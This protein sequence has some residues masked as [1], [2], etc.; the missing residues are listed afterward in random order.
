MVLKLTKEDKEWAS[1]VK[2]RDGWRCVICGGNNR[3]NAHHIIPR[4]IPDTKFLVD[5]GISLC[6]SHHMFSRKI[7]AHNN[8]LAFF[9]WMEE[10]RP[11]QMFKIKRECR[12]LCLSVLN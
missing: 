11:E 4:E 10:N 5:N 2:D 12:D 3:L 8:P 1:K 6:V 9:M 7:S